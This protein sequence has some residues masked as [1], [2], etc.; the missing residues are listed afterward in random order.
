MTGLYSANSIHEFTDKLITFKL[1]YYV[2]KGF[3]RK[4]VITDDGHNFYL[5]ALASVNL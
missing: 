3:T 5:K 1:I 2:E 4:L